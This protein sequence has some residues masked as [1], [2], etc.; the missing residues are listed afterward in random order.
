MPAKP[1]APKTI[2]QNPAAAT[3][4]LAACDPGLARAIAAVG[5]FRLVTKPATLHSLCT[6]IIGQQLSIIVAARIVERFTA[7]GGGLDDFTPDHVLSLTD[8][9]L[10]GAGLSGAKVRAVRS[11]SEFWIA[12]KLTP[13]KLAALPDQDLIDL[14][15]QVKGIGPWTAKMFL[16]FALRRPDVLAHEDLGLRMGIRDIYGMEE[17]PTRQE[18]ETISAPWAP[19]RTVATWYVWQY[20]PIMKEE[21]KQNAS[22]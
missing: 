10:R 22:S 7:L 14:L 1:S 12:H 13:K 5:K 16:I 19:W 11:L 6:A 15:V 8:E 18:T 20:I 3:R 9:Q 21:K 2:A 17:L 4:H